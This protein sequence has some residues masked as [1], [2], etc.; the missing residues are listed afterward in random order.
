MPCPEINPCTPCNPG[1]T[2]NGC[3][4]FPKSECIIY[5]GDDIPCLSITKNENLN[6]VL[7]H[8]KDTLCALTPTAY[9]DFDYGCFSTIGITT[10]QEFVEFISS[11]LCQILGTQE[12]GSITSLSSLYASIQNLTTN[13]NLIK[14]QTLISCFQTISGLTSP[15][16]ISILLTAI[17]TVIC[18]HEDRIVALEGGVGGASLVANDSNTIDFTTSGTLDHTITA[19]V[20]LS[21]T[22]NNALTANGTGLH[23]LSPVIT[24]VDTDEINLT[25]S[26][27]H[28]HTVQANLNI[29]A[30]SGNIITIE[31]DGLL[32]KP[33]P[34]DPQD[35]TTINFTVV[36]DNTFTG[37]VI[38]DPDINNILVATGNGLFVNSASF[39]LGNNSV[40]DAILRDSVAYS[41]IGRATGSTGDPGDIAAAADTVLRRS[42]T[43][44][45]AFGTLVTNN[46]GAKQVTYSRI[47]DMPSGKLLG[48]SSGGSGTVEEITVSTGLTLSGGLLTADWTNQIIEGTYTPTITPS[49]NVADST[50]ANDFNYA[51]VGNT[52]KVWGEISIDCASASVLSELTVSLPVSTSIVNTSDIAG[53]GACSD[54][55]IVRISG[56]VAS[57]AAKFNFTPQTNS[58]NLYSFLFVYTITPP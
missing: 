37:S 26:G 32:A 55:T 12:D 22:A 52:V 42:G 16:D 33:Q 1:Y 25:V 53:T 35:S 54:N 6:D 7:E 30:T 20:K 24:P 50:I 57:D 44:N 17:Q 43:G 18:D 9:A 3:L 38:I 36:D 5:N 48:R 31:A 27:T 13:L 51:Q 11:I 4:D 56:V 39:T 40:T 47:Q 45:L 23:V 29:S 19:D 46:I 14:N 49:T 2:D 21:V 58:N 10:E 34:I 41:V 8:I 28:N 15:Q